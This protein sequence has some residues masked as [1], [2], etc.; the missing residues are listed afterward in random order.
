M[1][2]LYFTDTHIRGSSPKNRLDTFPD[3]LETKLTEVVNIANQHEVDAVLHGG[4][5]F[6]RPDLS[7]NIV[8]RFLR[9]FQKFEAPIYAVAGNHDTFGHNPDTL[10]RTMLGLLHEAGIMHVIGA[11]EP[12]QF[13]SKTSRV[14][15]SG[16]PYHYGIDRRNSELDYA[17]PPAPDEDTVK[18]HIVHGSLVERP[19]PEGVPC[20]LLDHVFDLGADILLTGHVHDGFG[21]KQKNGKHYINPGAIARVNN[22][23]TEYQRK[24]RVLLIDIDDQT[25]AFEFINLQSAS[26]AEE[27]LDRSML[28]K[29]SHREEKLNAFIQNVRSHSDFQV[30]S[31]HDII[32]EIADAPE[33]EGGVSTDVKEEALRRLRAAEERWHHNH[34][35]D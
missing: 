5:V 28:E 24:P 32:N 3:A 17:P 20:T 11:G 12:V 7:P 22:H 35:T 19:L 16:Q 15:V 29:A 9:V 21:H 10:K 26:P 8:S 23:W 6:D 31:I 18:I 1:K 27:V 30:M 13:T 34:E 2:F 33:D 4:D 25:P 14:Q